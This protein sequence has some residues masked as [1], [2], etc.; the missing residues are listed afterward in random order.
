MIQIGLPI[1]TK[2]VRNLILL[3]LG[4]FV[5]DLLLRNTG[6]PV[7]RELF[8]FRPY[9]ATLGLQWWRWLTYQFVHD[10]ARHVIW[11]MVGLYFLGPELERTFGPR[12]FLAFYLTC[13]AVGSLFFCLLLLIIQPVG[14]FHYLIG[15]SG[16]VLGLLA[17]CFI[18]FPDMR[19]FGVIPVRIFAIIFGL[20]YLLSLLDPG[21]P[22]RLSNA[23]HLGGMVAALVWIAYIRGGY[24]WFSRTGDRMRQGAWQ[25]RRQRLQHEQHEVD[26]LLAKVHQH[27]LQGL[28][29]R[30]K[31]ILRQATER[32][33]RQEERYGR[34]DRL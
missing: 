34:V 7:I 20:I 25:R 12:R 23:C 30:E 13:G 32:Q 29:R 15:A 31:K 8:S 14:E 3:N 4:I 16:A 10:N 26:R 9:E 33:R 11:N 2:W 6:R 5:F 21:D 28:T 19:I 17:G 22:E 24:A 27:G 1:W 18:L